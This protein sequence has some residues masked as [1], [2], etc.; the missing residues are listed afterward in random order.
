MVRAVLHQPNTQPPALINRLTLAQPL[1]RNHGSNGEE[2]NSER[3]LKPLAHVV[4]MGQEQA[5]FEHTCAST[6]EVL[7]VTIAVN[8]CFPAAMSEREN[9]GAGVYAALSAFVVLICL[10]GAFVL[11]SSLVNSKWLGITALVGFFV[12]VPILLRLAQ[13]SRIRDAV[14]DL[15][16]TILRVKKLPFWDQP[17][18]RYSF[19]LGVRYR[20]E[21]IDLLGRTH[22]AL[23]NSGYF[24][25]VQW[26]E[27]TIVE[28]L[29]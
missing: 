19:F 8:T 13:R 12:A 6:N 7:T 26:L 15:G 18:T 27:D 17:H 5:K 10:V 1:P 25:G 21:Y 9:L 16:G 28:G 3:D 29:S 11:P 22:R 24:Q 4:S 2:K 23:C 14:H 20:V